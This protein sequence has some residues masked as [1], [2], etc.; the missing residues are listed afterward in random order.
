MITMDGSRIRSLFNPYDVF[1]V[2]VCVFISQRSITNRWN[3]QG[4][5]YRGMHTVVA[6][7]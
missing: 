4:G 2:R 5:Y 6:L 7:V 1:R 3:G